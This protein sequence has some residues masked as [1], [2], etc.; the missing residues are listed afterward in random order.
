MAVGVV[1]TA[2]KVPRSLHQVVQLWVDAWVG[3]FQFCLSLPGYLV[4]R[5]WAMVVAVLVGVGVVGRGVGETGEEKKE[6][7]EGKEGRAGKQGNNT[8]K[9][10]EE[11]GKEEEKDHVASSLVHTLRITTDPP[12]SSRRSRMYRKIKKQRQQQRK[13]AQQEQG[14]QD[15]KDGMDGGKEI[16]NSQDE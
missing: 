9:E 8:S 12:L 13:K 11:R 16:Q 1:E 10:L 5:C 7:K 15:E 2:S 3:L 14:L 4:V 6:G